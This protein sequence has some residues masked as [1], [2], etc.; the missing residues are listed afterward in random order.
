LRVIGTFGYDRAHDRK[1][2]F[3]ASDGKPGTYALTTEI[4]QQVRDLKAAEPDAFLVV[5]PHWGRNYSWKDSGQERTAHS[6]VDAGAD[7]ILGHGAHML[8]EIEL[9]EGRWIVY[10]LGNLVFN[11]PGRFARFDVPPF[12]IPARLL[13]ER[14]GGGWR[15]TL[16][17]Y[18]IVS[19]NL[20][21]GYQPRFVNGSQFDEVVRA[22]RERSWD[23]AAFARNTKSGRDGI[24][25][26][27]EV[28]L[29]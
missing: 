27:L 16:R 17:F 21:T 24:G 28:R 3:Y 2:G 8:Q 1:F 7:L 15:K 23:A 13:V 20:Q 4:L 26:F 6:L 5:F 22:L 10:S 19:D 9:Y 18:P 29:Q 12:S 25:R 14:A 11:S